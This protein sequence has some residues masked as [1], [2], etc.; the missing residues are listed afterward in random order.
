MTPE[1]AYFLKINIGIALFYAF[2]RLFFY[3]DTFF[4]WRR[5]ALLSFLIISFLY[6]FM[7]IQDWV[8]EQEPMNEIVTIYAANI[9]PEAGITPQESSTW[10]QLIKNIVPVVYWIGSALLFIRFL[11]QIISISILAIRCR[12]ADVNGIT[13]R[14][15]N[16][17]S[18]PFSFF[19]WIFISPELHSEKEAKEILIHEETHARQW[20]SIDVVFSEL[21]NILCWINPF[22]WLLKRE[23]RN[24]LEY[25]ADNRVVLSGHDTKS[26]QFHLLGLANQKAAANLYNSFNVLPLKN[27]IIMMNRKKTKS[28]GRTKY[29][30]FIPLAALLMLFSNIE[31]VARATGAITKD[32]MNAVKEITPETN[33]PVAS[34]NATFAE[35]NIYSGKVTDAEGKAIANANIMLKKTGKVITSNAQGE[36]TIKAQPMDILII[37]HKDFSSKKIL[38]PKEGNQ[39]M[40]IILHQKEKN[41]NGNNATFSVVEEMPQYPGGEPALLQYIFNN[42]KYPAQSLKSGVQGKVYVRFVVTKTGDIGEIKIMKSLD[43][44]CD[45]EAI[46]V[47]KSMSKWVPGKQK[48]VNVP[49]YYVVPIN[50][51]LKKKA[52]TKD[53]TSIKKGTSEEPYTAVQE[54]PQYPGGEAALLQYI[55]NNLKYPV[56]D[57]SRVEGKVYI[58]VAISENGD[59]ENPTIMRSLDPYCDKEAIRVIKSMPKWI[60]GKQNG[61]NVPVYYIIP[62]TFKLYY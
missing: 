18:S 26:Y 23:V 25:M 22:S 10:S 31:T 52:I 43:Q 2:Y 45:A 13:V 12:K 59:V 6:P 37:S 27:R 56:S 14:I 11:I 5:Y 7:N 15:L 4:H 49:V 32:V 57:N 44:Y 50:F 9:L 58:R 53:G 54:M 62:I 1:L 17:P 61:V 46:R 38:L 55:H 34:S 48:G 21:M 39:D 19:H 8:K 36:F 3:R 40:T 24:N 60:P 30:M 41:N 33:A 35:T 20:H 47:I 28:I 42:L 16:K 29:T 51:M